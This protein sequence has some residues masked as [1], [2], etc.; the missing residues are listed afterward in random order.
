MNSRWYGSILVLVSAVSFGFMPIFALLAY[1]EG[2]GVQELLFIRFILAFLLTGVFLGLT[3]KVSIPPRK[4][5][6]V[7][8]ALGG[9]GY[10]LQSSLY[11]TALLHI[12]VPVAALVLDTYP[13]FVTAGSLALGWERISTYLILSLL[14]ASAGL[15]LVA[16]P[17]FN[18]SIVGISMALGAAVTY[19]VYILVSTRVLKGL[20][21]EVGSFF[22]MGAASLTFGIS[23]L[24]MGELHIA[25]NFEAWIWVVMISFISTFI[26]I[27]TFFQGLK[28]IGPSRTSILSIAELVTSVVVASIVFNDAL[29]VTQ[30]IGGLLIL[31]AMIFAAPSETLRKKGTKHFYRQ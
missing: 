7:L 12:P 27:I 16:N 30:W 10:F 29:S 24:L 13:A 18:T 23:C 31:L 22:V 28:L 3:G 5:L 25:W 19:T 6:L 20:S 4:H 9:I 14:L 1:E 8:L 26:A 21:G 17:I 11:F 2:V 15:V